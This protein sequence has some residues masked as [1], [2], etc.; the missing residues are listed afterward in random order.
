MLLKEFLKFFC[1][2]NFIQNSMIKTDI[3][4]MSYKSFKKYKI[5][6]S[7]FSVD[8]FSYYI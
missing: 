1:T 3:E 5:T 7:Q 4:E 2:S 6:A 8:F